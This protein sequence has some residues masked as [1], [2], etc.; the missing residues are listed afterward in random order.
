MPWLPFP[1]YRMIWPCLEPSR[2]ADHS[3]DLPCCP[4][5]KTVRNPNPF[6]PARKTGNAKVGFFI[7]LAVFIAVNAL[8]IF[9]NLATSSDHL[10]FRWPLLGWGIGIFFHALAVFFL[11]HRPAPKN[12]LAQRP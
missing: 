8:L 5:E 2:P 7:H 1:F 6:A 9:I 4:K 10:W 3:A 12:G 11:A